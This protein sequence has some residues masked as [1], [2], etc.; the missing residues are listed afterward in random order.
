MSTL[1]TGACHFC[2]ICWPK[3]VPVPTPEPEWEETSKTQDK[4]TGFRE[5]INWKHQSNLPQALVPNSMPEGQGNYLVRL[6]GLEDSP[7]FIGLRKVREY[8]RN[9]HYEEICF[10][11]WKLGWSSFQDPPWGQG[12]DKLIFLGAREN[13]GLAHGSF[14]KLA[15]GQEFI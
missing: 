3:Q 13:K 6:M 14:D 5:A 9:S 8:N 4:G 2:F 7:G 10:S 1:G 15:S 11:E 12:R